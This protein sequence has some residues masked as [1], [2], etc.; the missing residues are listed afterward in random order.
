MSNELNQKSKGFMISAKEVDAYLEILNQET[1]D[2][3]QK[4]NRV[5][6]KDILEGL[7]EEQISKFKNSLIYYK[8]KESLMVI[9]NPVFS[10][11]PK[12]A[13]VV[14]FWQIIK[15]KLNV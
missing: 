5:Q 2:L 12:L 9:D 1:D 8:I 15:E 14:K 4:L 13:P 6:D 10:E 7:S 11:D 3:I